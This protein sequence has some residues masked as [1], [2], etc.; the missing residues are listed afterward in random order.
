[1]L[2]QF[3]MMM[4][5]GNRPLRVLIFGGIF[6]TWVIIKVA[7]YLLNIDTDV[8]DDISM[9]YIVVIIVSAW[10]GFGLSIWAYT[11]LEKIAEQNGFNQEGD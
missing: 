5:K 4:S 1:M 11:K 7:A 10:V 8:S 2:K 3:L 6:L 9:A